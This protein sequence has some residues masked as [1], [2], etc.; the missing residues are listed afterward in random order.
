VSSADC[1]GLTDV[2]GSHGAAKPLGRLDQD[3]VAA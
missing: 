2:V 3:L 1:S